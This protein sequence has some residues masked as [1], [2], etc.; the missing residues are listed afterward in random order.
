MNKTTLFIPLFLLAWGCAKNPRTDHASKTEDTDPVSLAF[1][2]DT[3]GVPDSGLYMEKVFPLAGLANSND[4]NVIYSTRPNVDLDSNGLYDQ[5]TSDKSAIKNADRHAAVLNL[6]MDIIVPPNAIS[7]SPQ[8][9]IIFI[10]GGGF[11]AGDKAAWKPEAISYARSGYVVASINYRL[12]ATNVAV[13]D[14]PARRRFAIVCALEDA[15][16]AVRFLKQNASMYHIDPTRIAVVGGS[17]GGAIT[18]TNAVEHD[19]ENDGR[20]ISDF[21]GISSRPDASVSTGAVL[22]APTDP[23][24][25]PTFLHYSA[26]DSPV[27][28]FHAKPEDSSTGFTWA[29][30]AIPTRQLINNSGNQCFLVPQPNLTHTVNLSVDSVY[31]RNYIRFF[32]WE[33]LRL[34]DLL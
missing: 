9:L 12:T 6:K 5:F 22:Y 16:N 15:Q 13:P 26:D 28:M 30:N 34:E 2:I 11:V 31:F 1:P 29:D 19:A 10:H 24:Y 7:G 3:T 14:E 4:T 21:P 23:G 25:D 8:P 32:F 20:V 17:A 33:K 18:L 27:L